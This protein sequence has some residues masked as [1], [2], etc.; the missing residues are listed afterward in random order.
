MVR[1]L[2]QGLDQVVPILRIYGPQRAFAYALKDIEGG[3][4]RGDVTGS[5]IGP[6]KAHHKHRAHADVSQE[7][8]QLKV[9]TSCLI[10]IYQTT[11][12]HNPIFPKET[13]GG[14]RINTSSMPPRSIFSDFLHLR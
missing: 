9:Q 4:E 7:T 12:T 3:V 8:Q 10:L 1:R 5:A 11:C 14:K 6:L 2:L 13:L